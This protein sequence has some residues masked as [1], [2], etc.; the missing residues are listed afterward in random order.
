MFHHQQMI[1]RHCFT[2]SLIWW[3]QIYLGP[4]KIKHFWAVECSIICLQFEEY[5]SEW[6]SELSAVPSQTWSEL[7]RMHTMLFPTMDF[8][9]V[10]EIKSFF[11]GKQEDQHFQSDTLIQEVSQKLPLC[12]ND[13]T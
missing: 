10:P 9:K 2:L 12:W 5:V 7:L 6:K 1:S 11:S 8:T 13:I 4:E 3:C